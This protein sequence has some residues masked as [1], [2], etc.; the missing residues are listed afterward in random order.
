MCH[1]VKSPHRSEL[2]TAA[3]AIH[4]WVEG[5]VERPQSGNN[6]IL[7]KVQS[8]SQVKSYNCNRH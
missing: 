7:H 1:G 8:Y 6:Y 4:L 3:A 5:R 2:E